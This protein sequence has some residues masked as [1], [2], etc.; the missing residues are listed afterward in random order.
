MGALRYPAM[1]PQLRVKQTPLTELRAASYNPRK[2]TRTQLE[3]LKRSLEEFGAVEPAV[4]LPDGELVGGHQRVEAARELGWSTFPTVRVDLDPIQAKALNLALN[5][6]AGDWDTPLLAELVAELDDQAD[7]GIV[8][9][10]GFSD[11][12]IEHLIARLGDER[13]ERDDTKARPA[14]PRTKLGDVWQLDEH[15]LVCGDATDEGAY[16]ALLGDEQI[17]LVWTDP[18]YGV[19]VAEIANRRADRDHHEMAG[20]EVDEAGAGELT[21]AAL[22]LAVSRATPGTPIYV[23]HADTLGEAFR[24]ALR[25]AGWELHQVLVWV[26]DTMVLG[27][28][29]YQ[30]RHEPILYGWAPGAAHRWYGLHDKTTV[31]GDAKTRDQLEAL[32]KADLVDLAERLIEDAPGSVIST[33][34]PRSSVEH[35]TIKPVELIIGHIR[36]SSKRDDLVLDPFVGSGSTILA[37]ATTNRRARAIELDPGYCD[38]TIARWQLET[39]GKAER[40]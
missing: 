22:E 1:A 35:P 11:S 4:A 38:V 5:K 28:Q 12:E 3:A 2:I 16:R 13:A 21:R 27:R 26:K 17:D 36:N 10:T 37:C 6:I 40:A 24:R 33:T 31:A 25:E 34:R 32:E 8:A 7:A 29:D 39:G 9:A 30:W 15:R 20:D 19:D 18:P 23:C 14:K